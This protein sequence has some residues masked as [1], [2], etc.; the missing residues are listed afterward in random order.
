MKNNDVFALI[1]DEVNDKNLERLIYQQYEQ[2][3]WGTSITDLKRLIELGDLSQYDYSVA[4]IF[5][6]RDLSLQY[7]YKECFEIIEEHESL[8]S[9]LNESNSHMALKGFMFH[10]F[11]ISLGYMGRRDSESYKLF[12]EKCL[13]IYDHL[14]AEDIKSDFLIQR[15][16][17]NYY[18]ENHL[19]VDGICREYE[20]IPE[21][22]HEQ[23]GINLRVGIINLLGY[24]KSENK[25]F[26][27]K[28]C[29]RDMDK[30]NN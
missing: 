30:R 6:A 26:L 16:D 2:D 12:N 11:A 18:Y 5:L 14:E 20:S 7:Q 13:K 21:V 25:K 29:S 22:F 10:Q 9:N 28:D 8:V 27:Y 15:T 3:Q 23:K 1:I 19:D 24:L 17:L 4:K